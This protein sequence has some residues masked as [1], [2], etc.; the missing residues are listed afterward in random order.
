MELPTSANENLPVLQNWMA[1]NSGSP[2]SGTF[3]YPLY[4][5]SRFLQSI[6]NSGSPYNFFNTMPSRAETGIVQASLI[7]RLD[8]H[9][10]HMQPDHSKTDISRYHGGSI[11]DEIAAL[12]SLCLGVRVRAGGVSRYFTNPDKEP[13]GVPVAWDWRPIP[14]LDLDKDRLVLPHVAGSR[15]L[16]ELHRLGWLLRLSPDQSIALVRAARLYQDALWISESEPALAW[17]MFVSSLETS[18]T[19][20]NSENKT[21]AERLAES[22][23]DL[24]KILKE[25]G[26]DDLVKNV[27]AQIEASLGATKKFVDFTLHFF[28]EPPMKRPR[29]NFQISWDKKQMGKVLRCVYNYRSKA[30]HGGTPFP[31]PMCEPP[32]SNSENEYAE[33]GAIGFSAGSGGGVWLAKDVPINLHVFHHIVR[34]TLLQWWKKMANGNQE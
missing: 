12:V 13:L 15:K 27:A 34:G 28:P 33:K 23:P 5:D 24:V 6:T 2:I 20:W 16:T 3:E 21:P 10:P 8:D 17:L 30:L 29:D 26:G 32:F 19:Q 11:V 4:S 22:K 25:A 9:L 1:R 18:A 14:S 7:L 31:A